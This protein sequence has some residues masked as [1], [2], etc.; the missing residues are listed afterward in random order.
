LSF[1]FLNGKLIH[2]YVLFCQKLPDESTSETESCALDCPSKDRAC[3]A[4]TC[5]GPSKQVTTTDDQL[6]HRDSTS[7]PTQPIATISGITSPD[8][9]VAM[10]DGVLHEFV[11]INH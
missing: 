2:H 4:S 10:G 1:L 7:R 8:I 6:R 3:A 5:C 9:S 11:D